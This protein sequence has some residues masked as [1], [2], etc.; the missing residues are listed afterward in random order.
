M[1][2]KVSGF[3]I[4]QQSNVFKFQT[5]I[6]NSFIRIYRKI[7]FGLGQKMLNCTRENEQKIC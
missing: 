2:F 6:L 5:D 7:Q 1:K 4:T 3:L